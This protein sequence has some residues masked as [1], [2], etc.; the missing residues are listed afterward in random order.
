MRGKNAG[1]MVGDCRWHCVKVY[2]PLYNY[3]TQNILYNMVTGEEGSQIPSW[4]GDRKERLK[5]AMPTDR[6]T[7]DRRERQGSWGLRRGWGTE[8]ERGVLFA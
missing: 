7:R 6:K 4:C 5:A 2:L 8:K 3:A 1:M